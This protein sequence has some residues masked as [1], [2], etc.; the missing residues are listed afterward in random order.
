MRLLLLLAG[1]FP[2]FDPASHVEGLRVLAIKAEPPTLAPGE[3]ATLTPLVFG[4]PVSYRWSLCLRPPL[5]GL[6]VSNDC[7]NSD[8]GDAT[9]PLGEGETIQ[10]TMPELRADQLGIPDY[11]GGV[12]LPVILEV[13]DGT[14]TVTSVYRLRYSIPQLDLFRN[15]N[16]HIQDV[17]VAFANDAG[18]EPLGD[19]SIHTG[20]RVSLRAQLPDGDHELYP[21]IEGQLALPDLAGGSDAGIHLFDGG[22]EI[23]GINLIFV[24]ETLRVSWFTSVGRVEPDVTGAA[25]KLDTTLYLDKY[26]V[27][28][29]ADVDLFVVVRDE[30]GGTDFSRRKILLR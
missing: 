29:P 23:G 6:S 25:G 11:T 22:V 10:V 3:T 13:D 4:A 15:Q 7:F 14:E 30:R 8:L 2:S 28:P 19:F 17:L 21:Q 12:Y 26:L 1:C 9:I 27:A 5:P 16:P 20:D 18:T 24:N